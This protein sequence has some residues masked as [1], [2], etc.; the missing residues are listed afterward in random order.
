MACHTA[1]DCW[2]CLSSESQGFAVLFQ[3]QKKEKKG[4]KYKQQ[5]KPCNTS[6]VNAY[7]FSCPLQT[8]E[9]CSTQGSV[10]QCS[11][12][13]ASGGFKHLLSPSAVCVL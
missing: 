11:H 1:R 12:D 6:N 3:A 8:S 9:G 4:V 7:L 5:L 2:Q 10:V 13:V